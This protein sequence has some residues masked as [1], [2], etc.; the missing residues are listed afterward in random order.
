VVRLVYNDHPSAFSLKL[1]P[2]FAPGCAAELQPAD[3]TQVAMAH[4]GAGGA[5]EGLA[6][7]LAVLDASTARG[8]W[9][10]ALQ[11]SAPNSPLP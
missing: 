4:L 1:I 8:R 11:S 3:E 2:T 6:L 10:A 9:A 5:V 7:A